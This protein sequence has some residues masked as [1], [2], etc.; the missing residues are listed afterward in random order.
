VPPVTYKAFVSSTFEDLKEHRAF[1]IDAIRRA[2][3]VVDP[4]EDWTADADEPRLFSIDR[5]DGCDLCVLLVAFRRG[6]VPPGET[7][8][9][10]QLEYEGAVGRGIDVLAFLLD[11][12]APWPRRFDE[13]DDELKSWRKDLSTRH[14]R[15]LFGLKPDSVPIAPA[16]TRWVTGRHRKAAE[17]GSDWVQLVSNVLGL[18]K[19]EPATWAVAAKLLPPRLLRSNVSTSVR[20][21]R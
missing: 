3:I 18:S 2:G 8:S 11:E 7:K 21:R 9:I 20:R 19:N 10:T 6:F 12:N 15:G 13:F 17:V 4:M 16:L 5:L 1:V 14:G